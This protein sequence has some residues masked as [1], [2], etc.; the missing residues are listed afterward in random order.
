MKIPVKRGSGHPRFALGA[1]MNYLGVSGSPPEPP[2]LARNAMNPLPPLR[3]VR[4][5]TPPS[6]G[7]SPG[8]LKLPPI[9]GLDHPQIPG[10]CR[11]FLT[12]LVRN[13][14]LNPLEIPGV[15]QT[16]GNRVPQLTSRDRTADA[17]A[18]NGVLTAYQRS[19]AIAGQY[20]GLRFGGY[21][22][23]DRIGGGSVGVVFR[24][25]HDFLKRKVAIKVLPVDD[26]LPADAPARF[27]S[28]ARV[29]AT[30]DHPHIVRTF[31]AGILAPTEPGQQTLYYLAMEYI[32]GGDV[33]Q[34]IYAN[35]TQ[36]VGVACE[37]IRQ[38]ATAL[39]AVHDAGLVHRDLKPSNLVLTEM[40][41]IKLLDFGLV[42]E[43]ASTRT[44]SNAVL[45]SLDFIA[46]EQLAAAAT[47]GPAVDIYALGV[48]LFWLLTGRL[49]LP[50]A[51]TPKEAADVLRSATPQ[52]LRE[53]L[54]DA[55][56]DL[57]SLLG[58]MLAKNPIERP[59]AGKVAATLAKFAIASVDVLSEATP[60][61]GDGDS[62]RATIDQLEKSLRSK[63]ADV[64]AARAA[65][66]TA[67]AATAAARPGEAPGHLR[68]VRGY[69]RLLA[70]KL[71]AEAD[72]PMLAD[73]MFVELLA[74]SAAAHDVGLVAVSDA[75]LTYPGPLPPDGEAAFVLHPDHG[76]EILDALAIGH[77]PALP[78]LRILRDVVRHHHERWDGTGYPDRLAHD[79]IPP[80]ARI[81]AVAVGYD[82]LRRGGFG[83]APVSH[84]AATADIRRNTGRAYDP[85]V[86]RAF[87][88][89]ELDFER[90]FAG[91]PDVEQSAP[92]K[93]NS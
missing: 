4:E 24:A 87:A 83:R 66:L 33:E 53:L 27:T 92:P 38:T 81:V 70:A 36:S 57:D 51:T 90:L 64:D 15:L 79:A 54:P 45:G 23:L 55:P 74:R 31:D 14:L 40:K 46:P 3:T 59:T 1:R 49:P 11:D 18:A 88:D 30:L 2:I 8:V 80:S 93:T 35:G 60:A 12:E 75:V 69:V 6:E 56:M 9:P 10:P 13:V 22:V 62:V 5:S 84:A 89:C 29:L 20:H 42:R 41:R 50:Q 21:R 86:A 76:C 37:W 68:R 47:A 65:V 63:T 17:L 48:T 44:Q 32:S 39:R 71:A 28:E 26:S 43:Y 67:L 72:W 85:Q 91:I 78:F 7:P 82:D 34:Y 16:L 73:P 25:E 61:D 58:K 52:R 19:R 77:G